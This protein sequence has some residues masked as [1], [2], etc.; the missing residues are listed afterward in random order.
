MYARL[1]VSG[2]SSRTRVGMAGSRF[3]FSREAK[4][5]LTEASRAARD[6]NPGVAPSSMGT[7]TAPRNRQPQKAPIHSALF[8][9]QRRTRSPVRTPRSFNSNAQATALLASL[10]YVH[11]S[12]RYPPPCTIATSS[13]YRWN[14]PHLDRRFSRGMAEAASRLL[15]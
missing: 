3:R 14:S 7:A 13:P 10:L 4:I 6:A 15:M 12:R 9:P 1:S 2:N 8:G 11:D 5:N